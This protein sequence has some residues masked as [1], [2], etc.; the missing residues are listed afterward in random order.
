MDRFFSVYTIQHPLP[1]ARTDE[2]DKELTESLNTLWQI[3]GAE[4]QII[5]TVY[6]VT[7]VTKIPT[8][9][10]TA[11]VEEPEPEPEPEPKSSQIWWH[12][13]RRYEADNS[14]ATGETIILRRKPE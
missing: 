1:G 6:G 4:I 7:L 12:G 13:G 9:T 11:P 14:D 5:P 10:P 3:D 2:F 8:P